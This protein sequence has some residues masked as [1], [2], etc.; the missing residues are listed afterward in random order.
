MQNCG[1]CKW[2]YPSGIGNIVECTWPVPDNLPIA[3]SISTVLGYM[4]ITMGSD[5]P[6]YEPKEIVD[7][8]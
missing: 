8:A 5:C 7:A 1:S 2:S 6:V 3:D 4:H